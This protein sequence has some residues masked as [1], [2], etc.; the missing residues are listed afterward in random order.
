ML[1][2]LETHNSSLQLKKKNA[3]PPDYFSISLTSL[4]GESNTMSLGLES[5]GLQG[6]WISMSE[7]AYIA[8][9]VLQ[10]VLHVIGLA[11]DFMTIRLPSKET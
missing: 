10:A 8:V 6:C 3:S 5:I 7:G 1:G 4:E 9:L 2:Q 11:S